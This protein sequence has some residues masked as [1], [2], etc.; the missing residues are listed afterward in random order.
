MKKHMMDVLFVLLVFCLFTL[1]SLSV[2]YVGLEVYQNTTETMDQEFQVNTSFQY[3]IEKIRQNN[4]NDSIDI[5]TVEDKQ[6]LRLKQRYN[7]QDYYTYIYQDEKQL[8]ELFISANQTPHIKDGDT[9]MDISK[10]HIS[11]VNEHL[12]RLTIEFDDGYEES[13]YISVL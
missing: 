1:T 3:I 13:H 7:N 4:T 12:Y 10:F 5:V 8:K 2:V 11:V 6:A 9:I